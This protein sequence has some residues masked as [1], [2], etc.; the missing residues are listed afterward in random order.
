MEGVKEVLPSGMTELET[1]CLICNLLLEMG[2]SLIW[3]TNEYE[4]P[5]HIS[6]SLDSTVFCEHG[7]GYVS[8]LGGLLPLQTEL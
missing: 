5:L 1:T 6:L 2:E 7:H 4:F 8:P 3:G